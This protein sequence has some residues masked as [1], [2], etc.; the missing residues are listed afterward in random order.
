[1]SLETACLIVLI[2]SLAGLGLLW[3]R[4]KYHRDVCDPITDEQYEQFKRDM[5]LAL[6]TWR[7]R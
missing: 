6:G 2:W 7:K 1:M 4:E 3:V 5:D